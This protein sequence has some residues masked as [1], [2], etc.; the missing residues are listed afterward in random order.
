ME[1]LGTNN[2]VVGQAVYPDGN[3]FSTEPLFY[4]AHLTTRTS[5]RCRDARVRTSRLA[6]K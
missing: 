4:R 5:R 6:K 2:G 1:G 3:I